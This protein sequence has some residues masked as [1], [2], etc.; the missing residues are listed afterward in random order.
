MCICNCYL[1]LNEICARTQASFLPAP[2]GDQ[3]VF[4]VQEPV[5]PP[6]RQPLPGGAQSRRQ[7]QGEFCCGQSRDSSTIR[8]CCCLLLYCL[9]GTYIHIPYVARRDLHLARIWRFSPCRALRDGCLPIL[10]RLYSQHAGTPQ[11][12]CPERTDR[13]LG[14][15]VFVGRLRAAVCSDF[16]ALFHRILLFVS[17]L[18]PT[19]SISHTSVRQPDAADQRPP[20][21][22]S[23][24]ALILLLCC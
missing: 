18:G 7:G 15:C 19:P 8:C 10:R 14:L 9:V 4:Q 16:V 2:A 13:R 6:E 3:P 22:R 1:H 12:R 23:P 21:L 24:Q 20:I 5:H 11:T 17:S